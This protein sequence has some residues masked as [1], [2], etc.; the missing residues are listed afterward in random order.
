M[1]GGVIH[2]A[3]GKP[4]ILA[5]RLMARVLGELLAFVYSPRVQFLARLDLTTGSLP[6][7]PLTSDVSGLDK[8]CS[9]QV[10]SSGSCMIRHASFSRG[11][12]AN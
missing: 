7:D 2:I 4:T 1:P 11:S 3:T 8:G 6:G 9:G 5:I 12:Y 10:Q